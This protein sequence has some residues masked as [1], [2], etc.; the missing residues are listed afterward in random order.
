M[1]MQMAIGTYWNLA[2]ATISFPV[3]GGTM[4]TY[5]DHWLKGRKRCCDP[6]FK[7]SLRMYDQNGLKLKTRNINLRGFVK[8]SDSCPRR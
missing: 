4:L 2:E 3:T 6:E 7:A 5:M 8:I 1:Y